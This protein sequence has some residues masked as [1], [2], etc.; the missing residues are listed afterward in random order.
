MATSADYVAQAALVASYS[1][2]EGLAS[3]LHKGP[4]PAKSL[5]L[6]TLWP[7]QDSNQRTYL[8]H[9]KNVVSK[10]LILAA[11]SA[12]RTISWGLICEP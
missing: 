1:L 7:S 5:P 3:S 2:E 9:Q 6:S 10:T 8:T 12:L 4:H 11:L